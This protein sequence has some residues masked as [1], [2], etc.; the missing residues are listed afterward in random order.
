MSRRL[1]AAITREDDWFVACRVELGAVSQGRTVEEA[2]AN[3]REAVDLSLESFGEND[4]PETS[5]EI[6]LYPLEIATGD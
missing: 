1:A 3:L 6:V 4:I 5:G 2:L